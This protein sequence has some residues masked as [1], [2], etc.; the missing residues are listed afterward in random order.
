MKK[1]LLA[2]LLGI[3][4]LLPTTTANSHTVVSQARKIDVTIEGRVLLA[5]SDATSG[6][7]KRIEIYRL[8]D[9]QLVLTQKCGGYSCSANLNALPAGNYVYAIICTNE[10]LSAQFQLN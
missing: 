8:G 6:T 2:C 9:M 10:V 1:V 7:I 4:A 3:G 5:N